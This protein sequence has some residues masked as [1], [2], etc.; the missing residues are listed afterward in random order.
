MTLL[1]A[2]FA[3]V[4]WWITGF[5]FAFGDPLSAG[6]IRSVIGPGNGFI[7]YKYFVL[8]GYPG[9]MWQFWLFQYAVC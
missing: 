1:D 2:A 7:G 8:S 5:A 9:D 3:A 6:P 4:G